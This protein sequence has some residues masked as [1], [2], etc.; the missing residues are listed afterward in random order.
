MVTLFDNNKSAVG[1]AKAVEGYTTYQEP[2]TR[3]PPKSRPIFSAVAVDGIEIPEHEI[4][5]EA[6]NHPADNPGAALLA[7]AKALVVRQLLINKA[8]EL[9]IV[10]VPGQDEEGRPETAEDATIR[11]LLDIEL[12]TPKA[13]EEECLRYYGNNR[14]RFRTEAL[15]EAR[16]ILIAADPADT[17]ARASARLQAERL[18]AALV[19]RPNEFAALAA[20]YSACPSGQ[21][22]GNLGQLSK[23]STVPEFEAALGNLREGETTGGPIESH[24]GFHIIRLDRKIDG[25]ELPFELVRERI[26]SWLEAGTWSKAV[27]QY[28]AILAADA[29]IAGVDLGGTDGPLVQ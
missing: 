12:D 8:G 5:A 21:Q 23:G 29:T 6:Q 27:A 15:Y 16:H 14:Q 22:G 2:D 18:I 20:Q 4:L 13:T 7:A 3:V 1:T 17:D 26:A 11:A 25:R 9:G 24:F 28:I 10:A 19:V